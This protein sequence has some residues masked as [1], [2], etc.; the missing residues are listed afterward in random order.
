MSDEVKLAYSPDEAAEKVGVCRDVIFAEI[1][2]R[3][4]VAKK[5]GRRTLIPAENLMAW[6]RALP[7]AGEAQAA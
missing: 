1:K 5:S 6:I 4:L 7:N 3:R 2:G